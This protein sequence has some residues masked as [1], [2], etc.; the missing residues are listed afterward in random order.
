MELHD[1]L[2]I[3]VI[4]AHRGGV[5]VVALA[6]V[7]LVQHGGVEAGL[8][9]GPVESVLVVVPHGSKAVH[10]DGKHPEFGERLDIGDACPP[11][12]IAVVGP[13]EKVF[14]D[15]VG[16][17]AE[18]GPGKFTAV[19]V[20]VADRPVCVERE[21]AAVVAQFP[22][23]GTEPCAVIE[24]PRFEVGAGRRTVELQAVVPLAGVV[25]VVAFSL[26]EGVVELR[27]EIEEELLA[28]SVLQLKP[29]LE[30]IVGCKA[31]RG[32][33]GENVASVRDESL[34][35][36]LAAAVPEIVV[37]AGHRGSL[38]L[39]DALRVVID[40]QLA[41]R[42]DAAHAQVQFADQAECDDHAA[43]IRDRGVG[44]IADHGNL[45]LFVVARYH[46]VGRIEESAVIHHLF[47]A[48]A[49]QRGAQA[50]AQIA[51]PAILEFLLE[52]EIHHFFPVR[53]DARKL[54]GITHLVDDLH[55][56]DHLG[57]QVLEGHLRVVEEESLA[58]DGDF[59]DGLAVVFHRAVAGNLHA[60]HPLE[61]V[62]Q[63]LVLPDDEGGGV[64][65]DGV[66]PHLDGIA[67]GRNLGRVEH[68][69][70]LGQVNGAQVHGLLVPGE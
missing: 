5:V 63:H 7:P 49:G 51:E 27:L 32:S 12:V 58:A 65:D 43:V 37:V 4:V 18:L 28:G 48:V 6:I 19:G 70:I 47:L 21:A 60:R 14:D 20:V 29:Q 44:A 3:I 10:I 25:V 42:L 53:G 2:Q 66:L 52:F 35:L 57:R 36:R 1:F 41:V 55:L 68:L 39:L 59:L 34:S 61:Q 15:R 9:A 23:A 67:D 62:F 8:A 69:G 33:I 50:A 54:L 11:G 30:S 24:L 64:E 31:F 17:R 46:R 22:D 13:V 26:S 45:V 38:H 56:I 40:A 16:S